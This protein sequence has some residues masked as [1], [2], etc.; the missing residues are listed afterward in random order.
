MWLSAVFLFLLRPAINPIPLTVFQFRF[1]LLTPLF[2]PVKRGIPAG[3]TK[4]KETRNRL[5]S[6]NWRSSGP[7]AERAACITC[8]GATSRTEEQLLLIP[9]L[10]SIVPFKNDRTFFLVHSMALFYCSCD[11][12]PTFLRPFPH[13]LNTE[14]HNVLLNREKETNKSFKYTDSG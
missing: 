10:G 14:T 13:D 2:S 6:D 9:V 3:S 4:T 1:L 12:L 8:A 5:C 7:T 11:L